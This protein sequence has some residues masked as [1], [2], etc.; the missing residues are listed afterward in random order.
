MVGG[1]GDGEG[2][3]LRREEKGERWELGRKR[4][5]GGEGWVVGR[6]EGWEE[7]LEDAGR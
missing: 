3:D 7:G 6:G 5:G 2:G 1:R 4:G